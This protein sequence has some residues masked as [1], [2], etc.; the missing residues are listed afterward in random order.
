MRLQ[1]L[2]KYRCKPRRNILMEKFTHHVVIVDK[3]V[4]IL[5][6]VDV[7]W[8]VL[9]DNNEMTHGKDARS[10]MARFVW[11]VFV[12]HLMRTAGS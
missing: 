9:P 3:S 2:F 8:D 1:E 5:V 4:W 12:W 7:L 6:F 11:V 10:E